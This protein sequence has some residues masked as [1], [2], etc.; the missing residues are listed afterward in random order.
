MNF[1]TSDFYKA[2]QDAPRPSID[3]NAPHRCWECDKVRDDFSK[4]NVGKVPDD[5]LHYHGDSISL[6]SPKAFRYFMPRYVEFTINNPDANAVDN[7]L[8]N[9]S[10]DDPT[11][12]F[13][14]GRCDAFTK[15]RE[16]IIEYL[17]YR[18]TLPDGEYD[19]EW[20]GPGIDY[21]NGL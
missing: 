2:F 18:R 1:S 11:S 4:Y 10:P 3:E 7:L 19:E 9:L 6:L 13:R 14:K 8:F 16:A 15:E 17:Q 12:E 5:V 21:W 20:I